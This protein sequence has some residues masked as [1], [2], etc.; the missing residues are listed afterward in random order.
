LPLAVTSFIV[1][2]MPFSRLPTCAAEWLRNSRE[3]YQSVVCYQYMIYAG[4]SQ[5]FWP[6]NCIWT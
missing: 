2:R 3:K 6:S 1:E 4:Y 5:D